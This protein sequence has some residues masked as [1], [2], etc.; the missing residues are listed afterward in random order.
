[1]TEPAVTIPARTALA[2]AKYLHH[3]AEVLPESQEAKARKVSMDLQ[4]AISESCSKEDID[5]VF[6]AAQLEESL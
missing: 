3:L 4:I 5:V 1:M 2:A 6:V